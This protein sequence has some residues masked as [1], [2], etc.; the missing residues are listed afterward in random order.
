MLIIHNIIPKVTIKPSNI[1]ELHF[2]S[3]GRDKNSMYVSVVMCCENDKDDL[4]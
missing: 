3:L 1:F 2:P 4:V